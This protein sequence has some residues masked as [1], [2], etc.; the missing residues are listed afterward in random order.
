MVR[1]EVF[2]TRSFKILKRSTRRPFSSTF[3]YQ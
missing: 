2:R 1:D 3:S